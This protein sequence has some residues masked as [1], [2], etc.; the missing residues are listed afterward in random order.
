VRTV[1]PSSRN[2]SRRISLVDVPSTSSLNKPSSSQSVVPDSPGDALSAMQKVVGSRQDRIGK[3]R[4][5]SISTQ[6]ANEC[7]AC[8]EE[9]SPRAQP[10]LGS[11]ICQPYRRH[12]CDTSR[13]RPLRPIHQHLQWLA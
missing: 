11:S 12:H 5:T 7:R 1:R 10:T 9:H 2:A 8:L 13:S 6:N 3:L 4:D